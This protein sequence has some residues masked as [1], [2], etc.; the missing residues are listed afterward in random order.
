[1]HGL[2]AELTGSLHEIIDAHRSS[3]LLYIQAKTGC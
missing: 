3:S 2:K 1:M